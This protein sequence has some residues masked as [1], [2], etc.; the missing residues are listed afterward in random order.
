[1]LSGVVIEINELSSVCFLGASG[2]DAILGCGISSPYQ[3]LGY[4]LWL[5]NC[6]KIGDAVRSVVRVVIIEAN[7]HKFD[8][9]ID[10]RRA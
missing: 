6:Y 7:E 10:L 8:A 1:M 2:L 9:G 4:I 5:C 3:C